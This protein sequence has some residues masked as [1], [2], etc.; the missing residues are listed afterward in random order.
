LRGI[1]YSIFR[2][3]DINNQITAITLEPSEASMKLTSSF[4]LLEPNINLKKN[5]RWKNGNAYKLTDSEK[6]EIFEKINELHKEIS[7]EITNFL[8]EKREKKRIQ[9]ARIERGVLP[10]KKTSKEEYLRNKELV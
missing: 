7:R 4:P 5:S 9:K 6:L 2:E 1:K 8:Y 3:P 10:K